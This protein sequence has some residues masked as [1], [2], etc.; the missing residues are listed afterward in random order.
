M[1]TVRV[2]TS[3]P[4]VNRSCVEAG[5]SPSMPFTPPVTVVNLKPFD[6]ISGIH[7]SSAATVSDRSPPASCMSTI[8]PASAFGLGVALRMIVSMPGFCQSSLSSVVKT[9]T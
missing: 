7:L 3:T 4:P 8:E 5:T 1:A 2:A 9:L 6:F